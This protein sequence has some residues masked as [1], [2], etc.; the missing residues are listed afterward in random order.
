L[1]ELPLQFISPLGHCFGRW[2]ECLNSAT[3]GLNPWHTGCP[4][5]AHPVWRQP[6]LLLLLTLQ[7]R[8]PLQP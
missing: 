3:G 5:G 7:R 4:V 2:H 8:R 1:P 6:G